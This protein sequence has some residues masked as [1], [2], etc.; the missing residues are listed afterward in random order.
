[1]TNNP[2]IVFAR[3][4]LAPRTASEM[5]ALF[6]AD[7]SQPRREARRLAGSMLR[8]AAHAITAGSDTFAFRVPADP[9]AASVQ[10]ASLIRLAQDIDPVTIR[11]SP[12]WEKDDTT[13]K[14]KTMKT[15]N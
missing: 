11:T 13:R 3:D 2:D 6:V 10:A 8:A 15:A 9:L 12:K 1:M 14:G 5:T 7:I 4:H